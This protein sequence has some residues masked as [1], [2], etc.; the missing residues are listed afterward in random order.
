MGSRFAFSCRYGNQHKICY[1][2]IY[3]PVSHTLYDGPLAVRSNQGEMRAKPA[4]G[5]RSSCADLMQVERARFPPA[6]S[7]AE[8]ELWA[9]EREAMDGFCGKARQ[10]VLAA[11]VSSDLSPVTHSSRSFSHSLTH[12][13]FLNHSLTHSPMSTILPLSRLRL[14]TRYRYASR[15][16]LRFPG[17]TVSGAFR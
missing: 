2:L 15:Q 6:L 17:Q 12:P 1:S 14:S 3:I 8:V 5:G 9:G 13:R 7:P 11:A 16:S 4:G 10:T